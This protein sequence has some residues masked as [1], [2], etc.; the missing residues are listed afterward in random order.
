MTS[1]P[2][3]V[4]AFAYSGSSPTVVWRGSRRMRRHSG[5]HALAR[6]SMK[7]Q[8]SA[9]MELLDMYEPAR[10]MHVARQLVL[11]CGSAPV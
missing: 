10:G 6:I 2:A 3:R 5:Q 9:S 7:D 1:E 4:I 8:S 11:E